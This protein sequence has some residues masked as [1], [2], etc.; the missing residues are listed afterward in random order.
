MGDLASFDL[1]SKKCMVWIDIYIY[2]YVHN[3]SCGISIW[4]DG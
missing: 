3:D 2:T 4:D 1:S